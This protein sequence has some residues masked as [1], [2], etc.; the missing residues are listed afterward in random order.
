MFGFFRIYWSALL[1]LNSESMKHFIK[2]YWIKV[3][4]LLNKRILC[5]SN[6]TQS[7][8]M[9]SIFIYYPTFDLKLYKRRNEIISSLLVESI[10]FKLNIVHYFGLFLK[11]SIFKLEHDIVHILCIL[12]LFL[13]SH[14][15]EDKVCGEN[16][17]PLIY[18][19]YN[20]VH[21]VVFKL[22]N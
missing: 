17:V 10:F 20:F 18:V 1:D 21:L 5:V 14:S 2:G 6:I 22:C 12:F 3:K 16:N 7:N 13:F 15:T 8:R 19:S 9:K 4:H 11:N